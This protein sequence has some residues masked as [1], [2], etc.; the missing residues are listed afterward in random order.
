MIRQTPYQ[1]EEPSA[2]LT[3]Y[4]TDVPCNISPNIDY[5]FVGHPIRKVFKVLTPDNL[6]S[7]TDGSTVYS[8]GSLVD[9]KRGSNTTTS[10][11]DIQM[12][13]VTYCHTFRTTT[14]VE[15]LNYFGNELENVLNSKRLGT[16]EFRRIQVISRIRSIVDV[17]QDIA[18]RI[19]E[20]MTQ[21]QFRTNSLSMTPRAKGK[22]YGKGSGSSS[23]SDI[24]PAGD[25]VDV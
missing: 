19:M 18:D 17:P 21:E 14:R 9:V 8:Q 15:N 16:I 20:G 13:E 25:A 6:P 23:S 22:G 10:V 3:K 4:Q 5:I 24:R 11:A 12:S 7:I 1:F 2:H